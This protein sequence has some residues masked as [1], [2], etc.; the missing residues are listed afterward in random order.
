[1]ANIDDLDYKSILDMGNDEAIELLRQIRLS[2]RMADRKPNRK[3]TKKTTNS[4]DISASQASEL[5]KLLM[6]KE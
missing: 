5:L 6:P 2:S 3:T 4:S 1:M